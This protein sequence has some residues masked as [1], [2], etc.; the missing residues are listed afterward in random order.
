MGV[1][2]KLKPNES[3]TKSLP[4]WE[5]DEW[6]NGWQATGNIHLKRSFSLNRYVFYP[7]S[8]E[9]KGVKPGQSPEVSRSKPLPQSGGWDSQYPQADR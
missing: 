8:S 5:R 4:Y 6:N 2:A 9:G 3:W 7:C 1:P